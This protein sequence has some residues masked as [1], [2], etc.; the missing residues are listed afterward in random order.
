MKVRSGSEAEIN[1]P[2]EPQKK[3]RIDVS[4]L[5]KICRSKFIGTLNV[6]QCFDG[7]ESF[8]FQPPNQILAAFPYY[9]MMKIARVCIAIY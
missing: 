6:G 7:K 2:I 1:H 4:E 9:Y 3:K 8:L 5:N